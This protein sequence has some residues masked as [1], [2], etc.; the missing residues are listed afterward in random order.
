VGE[1]LS[2]FVGV[3]VGE[4]HA[5]GD[6]DLRLPLGVAVP[7]HQFA[8]VSD[9]IEQVVDVAPRLFVGVSAGLLLEAGPDLESLGIRL[10]DL[11]DVFRD[12]QEHGGE[13][14]VGRVAGGKPKKCNHR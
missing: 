13:I 6:R 8:V 9:A 7:V 10:A 4:N 5:V 1:A 12:H 3:D 14:S 2:I 11:V